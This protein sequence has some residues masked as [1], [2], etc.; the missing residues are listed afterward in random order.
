MVETWTWDW[1]MSLM[2][3]GLFTTVSLQFELINLM[4][5]N[6]NKHMKKSKKQICAAVW[7]KQREDLQ[8]CVRFKQCLFHDSL[9]TQK[10]KKNRNVYYVLQ[11]NSLRTTIPELC[12]MC[13]LTASDWNLHSLNN[14]STQSVVVYCHFESKSSADRNTGTATEREKR[15]ESWTVLLSETQ[16]GCSLQ[17]QV[18]RLLIIYI[19]VVFNLKGC[20]K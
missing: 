18:Q 9:H 20:N 15:E 16:R 5:K 3:V 11:C 17:A 2:I 8:A 1:T 13:P 4:S 6:R 10:R 12:G 19:A 14:C 7:E